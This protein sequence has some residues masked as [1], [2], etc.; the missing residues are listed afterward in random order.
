MNPEKFRDCR[1]ILFDFGGT[2]DSDGE[3][4]L[5]RFYALYQ[6]LGLGIPPSEIKR[7]FYEADRLCTSEDHV[8]SLGL[9]PLMRRHVRYQFATLELA[10][11]LKEKELAE[12]FCAKSEHFLRRNAR[13]LRRMRDR[14]RLGLVSNFY[15]NV[16]TLCNE[17]GLAEV[18][19]VILDS[20]LVGMSKPDPEIF[21]AALNRLKLRPE[22]VIC[23]GDSLDRDMMP[24]RELGMKTIWLRGPHPRIPADAGPVDGSILNLTELRVLMV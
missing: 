10:D 8:A 19:D 2:L 6:D 17:V 13:M 15:G 1:A 20:A 4:W 14:Y 21:R 5:D 18:F 24:A 23:V 22:R 9:R 3:H 7:A 12:A 16:E 11:E